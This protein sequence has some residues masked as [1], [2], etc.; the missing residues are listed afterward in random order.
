MPK[1]TQLLDF[2][3]VQSELES[4]CI[5]IPWNPHGRKRQ[6]GLFHFWLMR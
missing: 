4:G 5:A 6:A 3:K 1:D 2:S